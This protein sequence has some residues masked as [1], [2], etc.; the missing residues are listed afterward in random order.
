MALTA[1]LGRFHCRHSPKFLSSGSTA[2]GCPGL[3]QRGCCGRVPVASGVSAPRAQCGATS[4]TQ[5]LGKLLGHLQVRAQSSAPSW[6]AARRGAKA[7]PQPI[8]MPGRGSPL[9][10]VGE[11][12][13]S[14]TAW[15]G[16]P[17]GGRHGAPGV[18][19]WLLREIREGR[20]DPLLLGQANAWKNCLGGGAVPPRRAV[21]AEVVCQ[22]A[23]EDLTYLPCNSIPLSRSGRG[24]R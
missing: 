6:W 9:L 5:R 12:Q 24:W 17:G 23:P 14:G 13:G 4:S 16:A 7:S 15:Q 3:N 2:T 11:V 1:A 18:P 22:Q 21:A 8:P 19:A 10:L 20:T